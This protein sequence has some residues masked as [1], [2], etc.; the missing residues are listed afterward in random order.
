MMTLTAVAIFSQGAL[1]GIDSKNLT[2]NA[3][4]SVNIAATRAMANVTFSSSRSELAFSS[5]CRRAM[6]RS[7]R[8]WIPPTIM[9]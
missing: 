8:G 1:R 3:I 7:I 2:M 6:R 9:V 4:V 5:S